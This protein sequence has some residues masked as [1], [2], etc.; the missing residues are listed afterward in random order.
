MVLIAVLLLASP[1]PSM[2]P[3]P[4]PSP[5][6]TPASPQLVSW[7]L[8]RRHVALSLRSR[9]ARA[10]RC[11]DRRQPEVVARAPRLSCDALTWKSAGDSWRAQARSFRKTFKGLWR[12][13][14][15]PGGGGEHRWRPLVRW[16]WPA[17]LVETVLRVMHFESG[18]QE[19][20]FNHGGSGAFGL[21]QLD[22][23]PAGVWRAYSQLVYAYRHKYLAA[24]GWGPWAGCR[25]FQ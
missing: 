10:D 12:K 6:V 22:P 23:K 16:T 11:M 19:F 8:S 2:S 24:G 5:I 3:M 4:V 15:Y 21:M 17:P 7:A 14:N 13:M 18:G 9:L 20:V 1:A 25:A